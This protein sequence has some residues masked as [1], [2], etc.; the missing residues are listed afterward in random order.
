VGPVEHV[1]GGVEEKVG[2]I[3]LGSNAVA[4]RISFSS[5]ISHLQKVL[6]ILNK[7]ITE[8]FMTGLALFHIQSD[9]LKLTLPFE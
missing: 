3:K 1:N 4:R 6:F 2:P 8:T 9:E 5:D 7:C